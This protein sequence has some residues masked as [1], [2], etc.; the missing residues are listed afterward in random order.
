M[1]EV[2]NFTTHALFH[3]LLLLCIYDLNIICTKKQF[4]LHLR[5]V[6]SGYRII[7][8]QTKT[9]NIS[10]FN[11]NLNFI[12]RW[13]N[14]LSLLIILIERK[15]TKKGQ[16]TTQIVFTSYLGNKLTPVQW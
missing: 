13:Y 5:V 2:L 9:A 10:D 4:V 6:P 3:L 15:N 7:S 11:H 16:R 1:V 12:F 14:R 8:G